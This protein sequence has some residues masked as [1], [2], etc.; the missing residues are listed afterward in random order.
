MNKNATLKDR[1]N[2]KLLSLFGFIHTLNN[3]SLK[4]VEIENIH[5]HTWVKWL[6][7]ISPMAVP[8]DQSKSF[9]SSCQALTAAVNEG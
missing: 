7:F 6:T 2:D 3:L 8:V 4:I 5:I 9:S 1:R